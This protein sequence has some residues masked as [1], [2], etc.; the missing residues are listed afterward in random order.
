MKQCKN[1]R[2]SRVT[3][4]SSLNTL[5]NS[6]KLLPDNLTF[7]FQNDIRGYY[8]RS[9]K[10]LKHKTNVSPKLFTWKTPVP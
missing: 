10:S 3:E 2:N 7:L 8:C 4:G 1:H 9:R 6:D 5:E